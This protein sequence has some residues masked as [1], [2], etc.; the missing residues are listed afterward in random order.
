LAAAGALTGGPDINA[1]DTVGQLANGL[2]TT[3]FFSTDDLNPGWVTA[4]GAPAGTKVLPEGTALKI[5][6]KG[7]ATNWKAPAQVVAP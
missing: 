5:L 3:H 2:F 6:R 4:G 7:T 1:A